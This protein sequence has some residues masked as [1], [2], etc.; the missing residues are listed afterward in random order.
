M[1]I[2]IAD[3][4][5][6]SRCSFCD[7]L[8]G[9]TPMRNY[10]YYKAKNYC[11][12]DD[13]KGYAYSFLC[14]ACLPK[15]NL[16]KDLSMQGLDTYSTIYCDGMIS[17]FE[18]RGAVKRGLINMKFR[19]R[20]SAG[21]AFAAFLAERMR[22]TRELP[23]LNKYDFILP[24]P[25]HRMREAE[26]GYNQAALLSSE[27]CNITGNFHSDKILLKIKNTARQGKASGIARQYNVTGAYAVS[28]EY[29]GRVRGK[30]LLLVDDIITTGN[31]VNEAAKALKE[32][33]ASAVF[34]IAVATSAQRDG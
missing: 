12:K 19:G 4:L 31:T 2:K 6:P 20:G 32:V 24:I 16:L 26:R 14:S 30:C 3:R 21:K 13:F 9:H 25:M 7:V 28:K 11:D 10:E 5:Y 29:S 8:L 34:A 15:A 33:G 27:L 18:Y 1:I 17:A 22:N 23:P